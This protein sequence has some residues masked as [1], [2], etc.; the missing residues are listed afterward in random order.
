MVLTPDINNTLNHMMIQLFQFIY[1]SPSHTN[2][3]SR[4]FCDTVQ[5]KPIRVQFIVVIIQAN[6]IHQIK[7]VLNSYTESQ[8]KN[9]ILAEGT[10]RLHQNFSLV[11]SPVMSMHEAT[12]EKNKSLLTWRNVCQNQTQEGWP[13]AL[14]SWGLTR[15]KRGD[16]KHHNIIQRIPIG[17]GKHKLMTTIML[18]VHGE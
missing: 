8:F 15:Q 9:Y 5:F 11:L 2:V 14:T 17:T 7:N 13:S 4:H 10:N 18:C 1:I 12:V 3:I 6:P 16:N